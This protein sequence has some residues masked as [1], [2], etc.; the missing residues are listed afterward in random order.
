MNVIS[1]I[2]PSTA[3]RLG[4]SVG[5]TLISINDVSI[6]NITSLAQY[7]FADI[8]SIFYDQSIPF[9][10]KFRKV[11]TNNKHIM[12]QLSLFEEYE[13]EMLDLNELY[14]DEINE[15]EPISQN[16]PNRPSSNAYCIQNA[17]ISTKSD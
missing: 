11:D 10:A 2:K 9:T 8:Q 3:D 4:L 15:F 7:A 5:D 13:D 6:S 12:N 17:K 1:K 14:L 16:K